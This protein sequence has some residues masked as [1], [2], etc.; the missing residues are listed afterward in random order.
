VLKP[1]VESPTA[2]APCCWLV[3]NPLHILAPALEPPAVILPP[4]PAAG[5]GQTTLSAPPFFLLPPPESAAIEALW[6]AF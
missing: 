3:P 4:D 6:F 1:S 5:C 2:S